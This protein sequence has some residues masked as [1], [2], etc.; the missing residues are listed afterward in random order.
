VAPSRGPIGVAGGARWPV[1]SLPERDAL[2]LFEA[3]ARLV[4]PGFEVQ[5]N[6][7]TIAQICT[8]LD[9]LPLAIEMAAAR[10]DMMSERELLT[11]LNDRS[12]DLTSITRAG[13]GW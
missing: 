3:R 6:S 7:A 12:R 5:P 4:R 8:R 9:R 10:L 1:P 11:N 13:R 2:R